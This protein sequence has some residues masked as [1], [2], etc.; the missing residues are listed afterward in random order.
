MCARPP[1]FAKI[2]EREREREKDMTGETRGASNFP[3]VLPV[4]AYGHRL[5]GPDGATDGLCKTLMS[6]P[7]CT[8][9]YSYIQTRQVGPFTVVPSTRDISPTGPGTASDS[10]EL[11][12]DCLC[13]RMEADG[14]SYNHAS[15]SNSA[16]Q[17]AVSA[18][19]KRGIP[20]LFPT[21]QSFINQTEAGTIQHKKTM[22][23][24]VNPLQSEV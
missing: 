8:Y 7:L 11:A 10:F 20:L 6:V 4:P 5:A 1:P 18:C 14:K 13:S 22:A 15:F 21:K 12:R 19:Q 23:D 2:G 16:T 24:T 9:T 3:S 17:L